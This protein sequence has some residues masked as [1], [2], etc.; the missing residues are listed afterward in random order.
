MTMPVR[1]AIRRTLPRA[2]GGVMRRTMETTSTATMTTTIA[3]A[4]GLATTAGCAAKAPAVHASPPPQEDWLAEILPYW[5]AGDLDGVLAAG[6]RAMIAARADST[7]GSRFSLVAQTHAAGLIQ[8]GRHDEAEA[9]AAEAEAHLTSTFASDAIRASLAAARC[10][11]V[12]ATELRLRTMDEAVSIQPS[13]NTLAMFDLLEARYERALERL[14]QAHALPPIDSTLQAEWDDGTKNL[15]A[16]TLVRLGRVAEAKEVM[17]PDPASTPGVLASSMAFARWKL[18]HGVGLYEVQHSLV[19][20]LI[21]L[22]AYDQ[23]DL[24]GPVKAL[25]AEVLDAY[26]RE[27]SPCHTKFPNPLAT[28]SPAVRLIVFGAPPEPE[29]VGAEPG[30]PVQDVVT[31]VAPPPDGDGDGFGD[32]ADACPLEAEIVNGIDDDDGCP[33]QAAGQ[34]I[35][36]EIELNEELPFGF[37]SAELDATADDALDWL[38]G[39]LVLHPELDVSIE[40]HTDDVGDDD[41]NQDLSERRAF[42]V[43]AALVDR[44]IDVSRLAAAGFGERLPKVPAKTATARAANRR[45]E[46]LVRAR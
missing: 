17:P 31:M 25:L 9:L 19:G 11:F 39:F 3:L 12:L 22:H 33:D 35:G 8:A 45:V 24:A 30:P 38:A 29:V 36:R 2:A 5:K 46:L 23:G 18:D 14:Q 40:G 4:I 42:A 1:G 41:F 10:D 34:L 44:G 28:E 27:D 20:I 26:A 32:D 21:S 37:D 13:L 16:S 7:N 43:R 6:E 15:L